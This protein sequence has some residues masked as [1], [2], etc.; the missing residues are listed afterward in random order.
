M[1]PE[2]YKAKLAFRRA[3]K[4]FTIANQKVCEA[5]TKAE[6]DEADKE[7]SIALNKFNQAQ[8]EY[9]DAKRKHPKSG[10]K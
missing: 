8:H 6:K 9:I 7:L 2:V 3:H 1:H 5:T 10:K 4:E